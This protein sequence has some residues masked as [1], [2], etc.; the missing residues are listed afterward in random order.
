MDEFDT[1]TL[2]HHTTGDF[3]T[4]LQHLVSIVK[5][6]KEFNLTERFETIEHLLDKTFRLELLH[7][8]QLISPTKSTHPDDTSNNHHTHPQIL[9]HLWCLLG[10]TD[11]INEIADYL[12]LTVEEVH[13]LI[14]EL[15][16]TFSIDT[17]MSRIWQYY[18]KNN[19]IKAAPKIQQKNEFLGYE[20]ALEP[21]DTTEDR[22]K[23]LKRKYGHLAKDSVLRNI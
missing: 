19:Q 1:L 15:H 17:L 23:R 18:E 5:L 16:H 20:Y 9:L 12:E 8:L 11:S 13:E 10:C 6:P 2:Y 14:R 7:R 4:K 21:K 22:K 3:D